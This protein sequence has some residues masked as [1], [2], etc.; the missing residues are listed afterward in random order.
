MNFFQYIKSKE[1]WSNLLAIFALSLLLLFVLG[2]GLKSYTNHN[3]RISVPTLEKLSVEEAE[4]ALAELQLSYV[5]ID[6]SNYNPDYPPKSVIEQDPEAGSYVKHK[7]KIY[8][9]LNPSDYMKVQIPDVLDETKRQVVTRLRSSGFNIGKE[10]F[11]PDLGKNVVRMLEY[12]GR[13]IKPGELLP[14]NSILDL[15]LGDGLEE[16]DSIVKTDSIDDAGEF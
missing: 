11:I 3:E 7:R 1:F 14:K 2:R 13:E 16:L 4:K 12:K 9:T 10:R 6:S 15:V 8:L 5:V